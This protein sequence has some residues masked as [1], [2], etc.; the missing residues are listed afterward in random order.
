MSRTPCVNNN[1]FGVTFRDPVNC[2]VVAV[3]LATVSLFACYV[4][5]AREVA[6]DLLQDPPIGVRAGSP[7]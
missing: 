6:V 7:V 3:T 4:P 1:D 2:V 5:S